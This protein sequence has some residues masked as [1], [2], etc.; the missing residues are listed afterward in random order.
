MWQDIS[1]EFFFENLK[2]FKAGYLLTCHI[3]GNK[4]NF[5]NDSHIFTGNRCVSV[6]SCHISVGHKDVKLNKSNKLF[7][8]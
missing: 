6:H 3:L 8:R 7:L 1:R 2:V 5:R 4:D